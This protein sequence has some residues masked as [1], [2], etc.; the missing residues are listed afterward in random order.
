MTELLVERH[1]ISPFGVVVGDK[2]RQRWDV[3]AVGNGDTTLHAGSL[4]TDERGEKGD[5]YYVIITTLVMAEN[6]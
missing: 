6:Y 5:G 3:A 4:I 2:L 1:A